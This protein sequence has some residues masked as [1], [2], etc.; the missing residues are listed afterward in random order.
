MVVAH[1]KKR[2]FHHFKAFRKELYSL[3]LF[4]WVFFVKKKKLTSCS[5]NYLKRLN[6]KILASLKLTNFDTRVCRRII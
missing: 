2:N 1:N 3:N 6:K 5:F 4:G